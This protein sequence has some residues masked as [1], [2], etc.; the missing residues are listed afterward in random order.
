M[1]SKCVQVR[2]PLMTVSHTRDFF[3]SI[4][5]G[6]RSYRDFKRAPLACVCAHVALVERSHAWECRNSTPRGCVA[7]ANASADANGKQANV[8]TLHAG[9]RSGKLHARPQPCV[10]AEATL[11]WEVYAAASGPHCFRSVSSL[12][13]GHEGKA[14]MLLP[15]GCCLLGKEIGRYGRVECARQCARPGN[16]APRL[17]LE[18]P[19]QARGIR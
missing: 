15:A 6:G 9:T 3:Q 4:F 8:A 7:P 14:P 13:F 10:P 12:R 19:R 17:R 2:V 18:F 5:F 16:T 11:R 1:R